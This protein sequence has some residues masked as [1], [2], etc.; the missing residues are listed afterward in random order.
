MDDLERRYV[1]INGI[2]M[3]YVTAGSGPTVVLLHG[4][5]EFWYSW[6]K[7]IAALSDSFTVVAPDLRG[8]NE[9]DK[10]SWGYE[11]DV[12]TAD[13]IGLI[14]A[15]GVDKVYLAGHDWGGALAWNVGIS[16][17]QRLHKL[18]VLNC[19]H[20]AV[21]ATALR[22]NRR[23]MLRSWYMAFFQLPWLPEWAFRAD[24][25][26]LIERAFRGMARRKNTFSDEDIA[27]YKEAISKPGA[28]TSAI[29]WYRGAF[30]RT[31][32]L[33]TSDTSAAMQVT[34]PTLLIW[35]EDDDALGKELTYD[36]G[37]YVPNL[38]IT[39]IPNCSH[40]VQQECPDEVNSSLR[41]FFSDEHIA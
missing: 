11:T 31:G 21:F 1:R 5:P 24:N 20:P 16:Y 38:D 13:V 23:Q 22:T 41:A 25:Y 34:V 29:N 10:P 2:Q 19:P 40:W 32:A 30:K 8:Y 18:A 33:A 17:P 28:L 3:H 37:R 26:A 27:R 35:G 39:Y 4:F 14:D 15:L 7:Q 6:R 12:L 9:T 36:T